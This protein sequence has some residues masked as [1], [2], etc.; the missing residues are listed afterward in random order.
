MDAFRFLSLLWLLL[1]SGCC[2]AERQQFWC[3]PGIP[4]THVASFAAERTGKI[5]ETGS[6]E[7]QLAAHC[8]SIGSPEATRHYLQALEAFW[9]CLESSQADGSCDPTLS[10]L[11]HQSLARLLVCA[12][13]HQQYVPGMGIVINSEH[14]SR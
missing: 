12:Q 10:H 7:L 5:A 11:Y 2:L 6:N 9:P 14:E 13:R 4:N 8:D 3:Q 1:C